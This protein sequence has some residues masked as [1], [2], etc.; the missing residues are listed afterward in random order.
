M[1]ILLYLITRFLKQLKS[2]MVNKRWISSSELEE[3]MRGN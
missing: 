1:I 3:I 2:S